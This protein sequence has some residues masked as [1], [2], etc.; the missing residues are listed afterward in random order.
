MRGALLAI[1]E[2]NAQGGVLGRPIKLL[3]KDTASRPEKAV[4]NVEK[5]VEEGAVMLFGSVSSA[6]A[7]AASERARQLNTLYFATIGYSN[8]V[9]GK[10]GH[11]YVFRESTSA[12]MTGRALG[13]YLSEKMPRQNL[14]LCHCRLHLG[15]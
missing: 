4:R 3:S 10:N 8:D 1:D 7:I 12:T 6:V 2:I 15:T 11:R 14:F 9:T 13:K 5:L